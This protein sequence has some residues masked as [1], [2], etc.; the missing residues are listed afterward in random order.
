MEFVKICK[1]CKLSKSEFEFDK[2]FGM[3]HGDSL[4]HMCRLEFR[5]K[6]AKQ[7]S[8][9]RKNIEQL[10]QTIKSIELTNEFKQ[11]KEF[12]LKSDTSTKYIKLNSI[13]HLSGRERLKLDKP[14]ILYIGRRSDIFEAQITYQNE[15]P[16]FIKGFESELD[17]LLTK[18]QEKIESLFLIIDPL[19]FYSFK[20]SSELGF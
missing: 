3:A 18:V 16:F 12:L 4:C 17:A 1:E 19:S 2:Y 5:R 7:N 9:I 14:S 10:E 20:M 15:T 8:K 6:H 13:K 11:I